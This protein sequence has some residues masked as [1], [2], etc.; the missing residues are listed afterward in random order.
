[1]RA[2]GIFAV[3][4]ALPLSVPAA[5]QRQS[6]VVSADRASAMKAEYP[7]VLFELLTDFHVPVIAGDLVTVATLASPI[8]RPESVT[9]PSAVRA[10]ERRR[11]SARGYMLP[12]DPQ[13]AKVTRFILASSIDSCLVG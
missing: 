6:A 13:A 4:M 5:P 11:I 12:L 8:E 9:V 3:I 1:M 2:P 7:F 10:L